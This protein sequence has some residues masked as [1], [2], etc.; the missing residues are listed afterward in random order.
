MLGLIEVSHIL[1]KIAKPYWVYTENQFCLC[2][3]FVLQCLMIHQIVEERF[4][5]TFLSDLTLSYY[6]T[7]NKTVK[8]YHIYI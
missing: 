2:T 1:A 3:A 6:F 5:I 4:I 7:G 8:I